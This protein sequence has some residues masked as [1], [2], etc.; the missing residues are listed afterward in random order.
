M[1]NILNTFHVLCL[2][3]TSLHFLGIVILDFFSFICYSNFSYN[4]F[5]LN[6]RKAF[7]KILDQFRHSMYAFSECFFTFAV[8]T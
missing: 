6:S 4:F 7:G 2:L 5:V 1:D 8:T 3:V